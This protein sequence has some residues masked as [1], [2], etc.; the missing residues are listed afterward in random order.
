[1]RSGAKLSPP[2]HGH[3][4]SCYGDS[5]GPLVAESFDGPLLVGAVSGGGLR[6]GTSPDYYARISANLKFIAKVS[7]VKPPGP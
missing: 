5:G 1:M 4:G 2:A 6:C 7:G 3:A